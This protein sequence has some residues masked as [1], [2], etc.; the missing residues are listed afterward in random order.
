MMYEIEGIIVKTEN[1]YN[2]LDKD[3]KPLLNNNYPSL[4]RML[5]DIARNLSESVPTEFEKALN[6]LKF[7][8]DEKDKEK[9]EFYLNKFKNE[10][11]L[12]DFINYCSDLGYNDIKSEIILENC[13]N[14]LC[15]N[16]NKLLT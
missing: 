10:N 12:N 8:I 6:L 4:K 3:K 1:G 2:I 15:E 5:N 13:L 14:R 9:Y 16:L 7:G 11:T